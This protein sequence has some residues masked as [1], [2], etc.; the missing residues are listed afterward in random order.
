MGLDVIG[1]RVTEINVTSPTCMR[2]I[3]AETGQDVAGRLLDVVLN[4]V[5]SK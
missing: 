4:E 5:I 2:E 3:M 1:N